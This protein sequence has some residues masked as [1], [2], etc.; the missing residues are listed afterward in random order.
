MSNT[1]SK[2][3]VEFYNALEDIFIGE[4]I[5]GRSGYVNLMKIK[6]AYYRNVVKSQ[7]QELID[8]E[9]TTKDIEDFREELFEKLYTFFKRYFRK[10]V[11]SI[12]TYN[13]RGARECMNGFMTLKKTSSFSG[14]LI[15]YI[16]SK[17]KKLQKC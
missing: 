15:C 7:L 13:A 1:M 2:H 10:R 9:L 4:E 17:Q 16:M 3:E 14:R 11:Q 12:Y 5:E 6:S 8:S